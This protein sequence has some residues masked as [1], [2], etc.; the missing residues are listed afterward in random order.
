[1]PQPETTPDP[2]PMIFPCDATGSGRGRLAMTRR[3]EMAVELFGGIVAG[4]LQDIETMEKF[5]AQSKRGSN[6]QRALDSLKARLLTVDKEA[7][8]VLQDAGATNPTPATPDS[9]A[10]TR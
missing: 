7:R 10:P 1:M 4:A 6:Y 9:S 3:L 8:E 5:H 2:L